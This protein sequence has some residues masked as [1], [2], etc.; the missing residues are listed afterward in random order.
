MMN[1]YKIFFSTVLA[2]PL[3]SW[4]ALIVDAQT[5]SSE[6]YT[7]ECADFGQPYVEAAGPDPEEEIVEQ[8]RGTRYPTGRRERIQIERMNELMETIGIVGVDGYF[9]DSIP[10]WGMYATTTGGYN[11]F[12]I[13]NQTSTSS[14]QQNY[15]ESGYVVHE[16]AVVDAPLRSARTF[17]SL[18][19]LVI[20]FALITFRVVGRRF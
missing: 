7:I 13:S 3:L 4:G 10:M 14:S 15:F 18:L 11:P 5:L 1:K 20:G 9:N 12:F 8:E 17:V 6:T 16:S 19:L 2:L